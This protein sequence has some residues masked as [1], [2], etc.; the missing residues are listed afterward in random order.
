MR[1]V[2]ASARRSASVVSFVVTTGLLGTGCTSTHSTGARHRPTASPQHST[3]VRRAALVGRCP[4]VPGLRTGDDLVPAPV[5]GLP[6]AWRHLAGRRIFGETVFRAAPTYAVAPLGWECG[7]IGGGTTAMIMVAP[8]LAR[9][10]HP[11]STGVSVFARY[12]GAGGDYLT[13]CGWFRWAA[14]RYEAFPTRACGH[15]DLSP[16]VHVTPVS[17][18][19]GFPYLAVITTPAG[20]ATFAGDRRNRRHTVYNIVAAGR[21]LALQGVACAL[22]AQQR[23]PCL[24]NARLFLATSKV[25]H[26]LPKG[27]AKRVA[28]AIARALH[29]DQK[30]S[31]R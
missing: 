13:A 21:R 26:A 28:T 5:A 23:G 3:S 10:P 27:R 31:A 1:V 30:N 4:F 9:Y 25:T 17:D 7:S 20:V 12:D 14:D 8:T 15:S 19:R 18:W 16:R 11:P 29:S 6:A 22:P 2:L 24:D